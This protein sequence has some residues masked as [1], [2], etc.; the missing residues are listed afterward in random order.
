MKLARDIDDLAAGL[1]LVITVGMFDGVHRGHQRVLRATASTAR[2][3]AATAVAISFQPHPQTVLRGIEPPPLLCDPA[4]RLARMAALGIDVCAVQR[5]DTAF[6][7]QSP[8]DFLARLAA[9]RSLAGVVM[10][11]GGGFGRDRSGGIEVVAGLAPE[12]GFRLVRVPSVVAGGSPV[13]SSRIRQ[14]I[15][16][17]KLAQAASMLGRRHAVFGTVVRGDRRGRDLGYPTANLAFDRPVCLPADGIYAVRVSWG[18]PDVLSPARRAGGVASLGVRPTFG[19]G[20]RVLEVFLFDVDEDLYGQRLRVEFVRRQRSERRFASVAA[21]VSQMDR[22]A[23]S[24]RML[25][26][27]GD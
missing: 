4:E 3:V 21:L 2:R 20:A 25:L 10:A 6:A 26:D 15:V 9:G 18:G 5:F 16:G 24:A 8:A 1:R 13:S 17:G 23:A 22:D 19:A 12:M 27:S 7:T 11:P 14:L